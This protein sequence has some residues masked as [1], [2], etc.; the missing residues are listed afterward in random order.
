MGVEGTGCKIRKEN[1]LE[2]HEG[3]LFVL[4]TKLESG[5]AGNKTCQLPREK[6]APQTAGPGCTTTLP[7]DAG[8]L[9]SR[10]AHL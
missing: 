7:G 6:S 9:G 1:A 8:W 3:K 5:S 10:V 2:Q 4:R